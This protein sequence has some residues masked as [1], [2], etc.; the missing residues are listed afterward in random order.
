MKE[1]GLARSILAGLLLLLMAP[2]QLLLFPPLASLRA[3]IR[4]RRH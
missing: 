4:R 3:L 2:I 1:R